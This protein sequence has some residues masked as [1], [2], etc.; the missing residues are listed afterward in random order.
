MSRFALYWSS[1]LN[2]NEKTVSN[3]TNIAV[4]FRSAQRKPPIVPW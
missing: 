3:T 1:E 4:G 2:T